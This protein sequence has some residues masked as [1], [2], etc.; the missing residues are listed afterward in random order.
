MVEASVEDPSSLF[1]S[2]NV[3]NYSKMKSVKCLKLDEIKVYYK[4][5]NKTNCFTI[6][7]T[8]FR[9]IFIKNVPFQQK[10][11]VLLFWKKLIHFKGKLG[12]LKLGHYM[13]FRGKKYY[14]IINVECK[15]QIHAYF[16][17]IYVSILINVL[18]N[19]CAYKF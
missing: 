9:I 19:T 10:L 2:L 1:C 12:H 5:N 16:I 13:P 4:T 11:P 18:I 3:V 7:H 8:S 14:A 15:T 6:S 17:A